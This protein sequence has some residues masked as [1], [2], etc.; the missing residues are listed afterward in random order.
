M[1]GFFTRCW[2]TFADAMSS[3]G[4]KPRAVEPEPEKEELTFTGFLRDSNQNTM[5]YE[6][7]MSEHYRVNL[8][9][10]FRTTPLLCVN[11][12]VNPL[13]EGQ[14]AIGFPDYSEEEIKELMAS[15]REAEYA[16]YEELISLPAR[17]FTDPAYKHLMDKLDATSGIETLITKLA[18]EATY[19]HGET[20]VKMY[21]EWYTVMSH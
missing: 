6:K 17:A 18:P 14:L 7:I 20:R 5:N 2:R 11:G 15:L 21:G 12:S 9:H 10:F 4:T 1:S 16:V 19:E 8:E 3:K 13:W